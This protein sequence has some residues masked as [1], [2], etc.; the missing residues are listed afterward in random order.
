MRYRTRNVQWKEQRVEKNLTDEV[1]NANWPMKRAM[2]GAKSNTS[3]R[4]FFEKIPL[5]K[6]SLILVISLNRFLNTFNPCEIRMKSVWNPYE[7]RMK[8]VWNLFE[9]VLP[10]YCTAYQMSSSGLL[11][12]VT[13]P[14]NRSTRFCW[15][16][17]G[18]YSTRFCRLPY[19]FM[20]STL[21]IQIFKKLDYLK[22]TWVWSESGNNENNKTVKTKYQRTN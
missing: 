14:F 10:Y 1:S 13:F 8:S 20:S 5:M 12:L 4:T 21:D 9:F 19:T 22:K 6:W 18:A 2:G 3:S 11:E 7:I 16:F 17:C 15:A